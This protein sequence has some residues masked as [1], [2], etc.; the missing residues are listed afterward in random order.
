VYPLS[1]VKRGSSWVGSGLATNTLAYYD[2]E[3]NTAVECFIVSDL[4]R[5]QFDK[6]CTNVNKKIV[7]M[8]NSGTICGP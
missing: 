5:G 6:N 8:F 3:L 2:K 7:N 1:G 4:P